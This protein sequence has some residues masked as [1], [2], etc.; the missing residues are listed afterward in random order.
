MSE[1]DV[2]A[3]GSARSL[4]GWGRTVPSVATVLSPRDAGEV[5]AAL[6]A[7]AGDGGVVARG[8]GRSYGD[9]AQNGGGCVLDTS[10]LRALE[11]LGGDPPLVRAGAGTRLSELVCALGRRR[12]ALPVVPGT[13]H[14]TVGGAIAAD[15]H[16]KNHRRDG[17]FAHHV[18]SFV[19]CTPDGRVRVVS[20]ELE[21]DLFAATVGGMGMTGVV[22]E[23]TIAAS[24]LRAPSLRCDI[25]RT[26]D[27]EA[28]IALL[29][30]DAGYRYTI[31]WVDL[32]SGGSR[33]GRSVVMR[34]NDAE[35]REASAGARVRLPGRPRLRASGA[36]SL[37]LRRP[38]VLAFNSLRWRRSPRC[39]RG[40]SAG[41]GEH[42]FP[43]DALRDWNRLYG[44]GGLLQYQFAVPE[45]RAGTLIEVVEKL[46]A[47]GIPIYLA[48]VKRFGAG[49]GGMLS[50]PSPG[51][52]FALDVPAATPRLGRALDSADELVAAA[53][54]RVYLAK[55]A[56]LRG[57]L[58]ERMYPLLPRFR[59]VCASVDPDGAIRSD[60]SMRLR[61][62]ERSR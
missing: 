49:S 17:S 46:R 25:D 28:A 51:W 13:R 11:L 42:F 50:F 10:R 41:I 19:L 16:G 61:L 24:P 26:N 53:G 31:A 35:E 59:E 23:A 37:A 56:R 39:A 48:V 18:A 38:T 27:L 1:H 55:D 40:V 44:R 62:T 30:Q 5:A 12:L 29:G 4:S 9:A 21:P 52:T 58:L 34:S 8:A 15:V 2:I 7:A 57:E 32:L 60:M 43:L 33:F 36:S 54:G 3:A 22:L 14:V 20:R 6:A 47:D 45:D